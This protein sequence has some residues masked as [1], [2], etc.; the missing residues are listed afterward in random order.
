MQKFCETY[1]VRPL[2][3]SGYMLEV[4][5][6]SYEEFLGRKPDSAPNI[7]I[8]DLGDRPTQS[9]FELFKEFFERQGYPTLICTP[10]E[11]EFV[12]GRLRVSDFQ[13]D[14]VY[15]RFTS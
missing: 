1:N 11:L 5:L 2:Y 12:D 7:A 6:H 10:E 15:K 8:V 13:I 14:I 3:G 4:L 9:E